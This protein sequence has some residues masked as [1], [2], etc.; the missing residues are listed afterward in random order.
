[1]K[2]ISQLLTLNESDIN[3][4]D[5]SSVSDH[6]NDGVDDVD[7]AGPIE[8]HSETTPVAIT[9]FTQP[10]HLNHQL[11]DVTNPLALFHLLWPKN[12]WQVIADETNHYA[13]QKIAASRQPST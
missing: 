2:R 6:S 9:A 11:A 8:C 5:D 4:S 7:A 13:D 1:M 12:L 10:T 3:V